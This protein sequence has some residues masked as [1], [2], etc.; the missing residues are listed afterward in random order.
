M[1]RGAVLAV[2]AL[3]AL[4]LASSAQAATWRSQQPAGAGGFPTF[5][6]GVGDVECWAA[7]RCLLISGGN[8]GVAAGLFAYDGSGWYRYSTVCGGAE[9]RIAWAGPDEFWTVSDQQKGQETSEA[10]K[11]SISLCHFKAGQIV[12]SYA[13]PIGRADSYL[14]MNAAACATPSDCWFAGE[15]LPATVNQG[16]FH[17]R[18]DGAALTAIPSLTTSQPQILD[19][20]RA[21][22]DLAFHGGG[23]YEGVREAAG[24]T[25]VAEEES[26]PALLHRIEPL[27]A[28]PFEPLFPAAPIEWEGAPVNPISLGGFDLG[29]EPGEPLWAVSGAKGQGAFAGVTVLRIG[30]ADA[31]SQLG[32]IDPGEVLAQRGDAVSGAAAEPG[33][34]VWVAFRHEG[35]EI[36]LAP[37]ARLARVGGDGSV[38]PEVV[39]PAPGEE[40][41]GEVLGPKG[42][43]GPIECVEA[44]QCWLA[45]SRGWLFHLGADPAANADPAMHPAPITVRPADES[46]PAVPPIGAPEDDSGAEA[47]P[48]DQEELGA[49]EP[50]PKRL[51]AIV[52]KIKQRLIGERI[53]ELSFT[54]RKE[55]HVRLVARRKGHVVAKTRSYTMAKGRHSVRLR[56]D[57]KQWPTKLDLQV[58]AVKGGK[59]K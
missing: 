14:K 30:A 26:E 43:A 45:T 21:V 18:W 16:A 2:A 15:R 58:H 36:G 3:A 34:H 19:P 52:A 24:D 49:E 28:N 38:E 17:L 20:G 4:L 54:L 10:P 44:Q 53:L 50:L 12:A 7:N 22:V 1:R 55:A 31:I 39:L 5:L 37:S 42:V 11:P 9:G 13:K 40:V 32:L 48:S 47:G 33:E 57:P 35:E 56:L 29:G 27:A 46:L 25:A 59:A 6:G 23:L 51:K 8:A 41:A